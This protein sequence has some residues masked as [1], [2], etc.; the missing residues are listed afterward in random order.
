[1]IGWFVALAWVWFVDPCLA[2]VSCLAGRS[3]LLRGVGLA[4]F[5]GG[6][7]LSSGGRVRVYSLSLVVAVGAAVRG[8]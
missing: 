4:A 6:A 7:P 1:M 5:G 2:G 8:W 3:R